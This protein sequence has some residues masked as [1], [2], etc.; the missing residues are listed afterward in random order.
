VKFL[1]PKAF[2]AF[3]RGLFLFVM[4][5]LDITYYKKFN[6]EVPQ[7]TIL[8]H[9]H[10]ARI[11]AAQRRNGIRT[12]KA[13]YIS[14]SRIIARLLGPAIMHHIVFVSDAE[15]ISKY[16]NRKV[17]QKPIETN[18]SSDF[19]ITVIVPVYGAPDAV[20]RCLRSVKQSVTEVSHDVIVIDDLSPNQSDRLLAQK[21][22]RELGF[23]FIQNTENLGFV[24]TSNLGLASARQHA[25]LLNSDT[26]VFDYWLEAFSS[27]LESNTGTIT[28]V[29]NNATIYS[30]PMQQDVELSTT[31]TFAKAMAATLHQI[32][33]DPWEIP[34]SHGFCMFFSQKALAQVGFFNFEAFG[35]GYGEENDYS[36]RVIESGLKNL[37][38]LKTYVFHEGSAS[39]GDSVSERQKIA[40]EKLLSLWPKYP[41]L[42]SK[43][44]E[45]NPLSEFEVLARIQN[46]IRHNNEIDIHFSHRL[47]GGVDKAIQLECENSLID[48]VISIV[49]RPGVSTKSI[50]LQILDYAGVFDIKYEFGHSPEE[51]AA[52]LSSLKS[53]KVV[54]HHQIGF[55]M[56]KEI[57]EALGT[58]Y[59]F[60]V[61]DYYTVC[62]F[63]NLA[64]E[65]GNYCGEPG[66]AG[67]NS[68][69]AR[70]RPEILD[71][72]TWRLDASRIAENASV[73]FT[74]SSD[75]KKRIIKHYPN[76]NVEIATNPV[77]KLVS[78]PF[79][80]SDSK[81]IVMLGE[82]S[83]NKGLNIVKNLIQ[84]LPE[85]VT[86]V[87]IGYIPSSLIDGCLKSS[88][89]T[90]RL[91]VTGKYMNDQQALHVLREIAPA[92]IF[93]PGQIPETHSY[94]LDIAISTGLP[95]IGCNVGAIPERL[96]SYENVR[97]FEINDS[98][99]N[100]ATILIA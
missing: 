14:S 10:F 45:D 48:D 97:L 53:R 100:I 73:V 95:I 9:Y 4:R 8:A 29:S 83:V 27:T 67:C 66:I 51:I 26:Q 36:M 98:I 43:Y 17:K 55:P 64:D 22:S 6:E 57:L 5:I 40:G 65:F 47:G 74:P 89:K 85:D 41:S 2:V 46:F 77:E 80:I 49:V 21:L 19:H 20:E 44:L 18:S 16:F 62:P 90:G 76:L 99:E 12:R 50:S 93:F 39:F 63:I 32:D 52:A 24:R 69:I 84:A 82:L 86:L 78:A 58:Q 25:L 56:L 75:T 81:K 1:N 15:S 72:E 28:P 59:S 91:V 94:T 79:N 35:Y 34:T 23:Q 61:H 68:C 11:G 42:I 33:A 30:I 7:N 37:L 60:R 54:V 38:T 31:S 3:S 88:I 96:A 71:I 92:S 70:R 87:L 13:P